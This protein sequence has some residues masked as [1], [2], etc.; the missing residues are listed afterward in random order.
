MNKNGVF[1]NGLFLILISVRCQYFLLNRYQVRV[2]H[3]FLKMEWP[4]VNKNHPWTQLNTHE[5]NHQTGQNIFE[6]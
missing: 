3:G 4:I 5:K 1:V 6:F 2:E